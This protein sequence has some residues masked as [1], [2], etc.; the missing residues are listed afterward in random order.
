MVAFPNAKINLGLYITGK[1]PD[2]YHNL[3]TVFFP[4]ALKDVLEII[5]SNEDDQVSFSSSGLTVSGNTADN[6]CVKAYHLLKKISLL[7]PISKCIYIRLF[8]W[9]LEWAVVLAMPHLL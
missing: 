3:E 5:E 2:G 9:E 4:I 6:I 7:S 1:R 8:P